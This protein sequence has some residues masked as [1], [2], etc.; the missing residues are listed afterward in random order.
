MLTRRQ[1]LSK[2]HWQQ[3]ASNSVLLQMPVQ[4][5]RAL[6]SLVEFMRKHGCDKLEEGD[7]RAWARMGEDIAILEHA[8]VAV[9]AL[10]GPDA[11]ALPALRVAH[12]G[13][14]ERAAFEGVPSE[15]TRSYRRTKSVPEADLPVH[16]QARLAE[17]ELR[18]EEGGDGP[19]KEI[20]L[21]M[22]R[23][24]CEYCRFVRA[25]NMADDLSVEGLR[26]FY[27]YET[28]RISTRG[29]PLRPA[30][31]LNTFGDLRAYMRLSGDYSTGLVSEIDK[32]T[33]KLR[34]YAEGGVARKFAALARI[35]IK[36]ILPEAHAMLDDAEHIQSAARRHMRR[37]RA[38]ALALPPM[39][40]LRR[41]WHELRF[42]RDLVWSEDRYRL[43]NYKLR[44]TRDCQNREVY[45]GSVHPSV[46][47]FV[48][49]VLLQDE[50]QRYLEAFREQAEMQEWPLFMHPTGACVSVNY[51]SQVWT[52]KLGTGAHIARTIVYDLLFALGTDET[53]GGMLLNDH[54]SRAAADKYIA[55]QARATSFMAATKKRDEIFEMFAGDKTQI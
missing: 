27:Q 37:N 39:M 45:E 24:L 42:G 33:E 9:E 14:E 1:I 21:R 30:T 46:Q 53:R 54:S 25:K 23:K 12:A 16:W 17:I 26:S 20:F 13:M 44:K 35:D 34:D 28:T 41:E 55:E 10:D 36:A 7:A 3:L 29:A 49:A 8:C 43:R 19:S 4:Q 50:D 5:L 32:L 31:V 18:R 2:A 51:V 6:D 48:D 38:L 11:P 22:K 52:S 15:P 40:P 47:R